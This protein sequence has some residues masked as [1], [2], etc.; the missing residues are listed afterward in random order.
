VLGVAP[1]GT[2]RLQ[3]KTGEKRAVSGRLRPL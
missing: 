2:L 1:D 3:T